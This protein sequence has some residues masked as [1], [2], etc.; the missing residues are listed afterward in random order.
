MKVDGTLVEDNVTSPF[1]MLLVVKGYDRTLQI[2]KLSNILKNVTYV[3][4]Q[5]AGRMNC[6]EYVNLT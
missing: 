1:Q 6:A 2:V 5:G 3:E 4:G